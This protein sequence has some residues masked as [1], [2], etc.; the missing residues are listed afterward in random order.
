MF[1]LRALER[2]GERSVRALAAFLSAGLVRQAKAV[3]IVKGAVAAI[4]GDSQKAQ[5]LSGLTANPGAGDVFG[6]GRATIG[7]AK[8]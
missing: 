1:R 8:C 2:V 4:A 3:Q 5:F 7:A 6:L